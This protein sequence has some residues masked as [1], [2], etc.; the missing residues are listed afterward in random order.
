MARRARLGGQNDPVPQDPWLSTHSA[1]GTGL[2]LRASSLL[3]A[4]H[5]VKFFHKQP[6]VVDCRFGRSGGGALSERTGFEKM[7]GVDLS[8]ESDPNQAGCTESWE[9]HGAGEEEDQS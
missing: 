2:S 9:S 4:C 6:D 1:R 5:K 7:F 8:R 3:L